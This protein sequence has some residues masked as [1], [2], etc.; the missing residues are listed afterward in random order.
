[1]CFD[2]Q[3]DFLESDII[4]I[5]IT[6][7]FSGLE[8]TVNVD[9]TVQKQDLKPAELPS[10]DTLGAIPMDISKEP[11]NYMTENMTPCDMEISSPI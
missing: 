3:W 6:F 8:S 7:F 1:M 4:F 2:A 5:I 11:F 10:T 9:L